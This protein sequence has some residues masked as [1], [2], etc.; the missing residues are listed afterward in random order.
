MNEEDFPELREFLAEQ[1]SR[2]RRIIVGLIVGGLLSIV[3]G[4]VIFALAPSGKSPSMGGGAVAVMLV[5]VG[6][7]MVIRGIISAVTDIDFRDRKEFSDP[8]TDASINK[9]D[10]EQTENSDHPGASTSS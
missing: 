8:L 2:H 3:A 5:G 7:V 9:T 6:A 1:Q 4:F 10:A